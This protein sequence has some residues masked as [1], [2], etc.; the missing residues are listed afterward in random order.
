VPYNYWQDALILFSPHVVVINHMQGKRSRLIADWVKRN[1][2]K[3]VVMFNEGIIEFEDRRELFAMQ[4]GSKFVDKFLCWNQE[5]ADIVDGIVVGCPRFDFYAK[6]LLA[7][8]ELTRQKYG[9]SPDK[10]MVLWGDSWPSARFDYQMQDFHR[11]NWGDLQN[12]SAKQWGD[13]ALFAKDQQEKAE[14]FKA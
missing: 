6:E 10:Q 2:G 11:A 8:R 13:A 12:T 7:K 5:V 1:G 9:I 3:V 14:K 4:R